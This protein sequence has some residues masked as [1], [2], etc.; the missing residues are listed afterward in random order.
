MKK[1]GY[2]LSIALLLCAAAALY[3]CIPARMLILKWF[4]LFTQ[5][6]T[7]SL[8][9]YIVSADAPFL[10]AV[11][12]NFFHAAFLF[13]YP[14]RVYMAGASCLGEW[15]AMAGAVL[16]TMAAWSFWYALG[17]LF[18]PKKVQKR[19][20]VGTGA[21]GSACA[22]VTLLFGNPLPLTALVTVLIKGSFAAGGFGVAAA[23]AVRALL[24]ARYCTLYTSYLP[25]SV[26]SGLMA[27][28]VALILLGAILAWRCRIKRVGN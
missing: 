11:F 8:Q 21:A 5:N 17:K 24:Y 1:R 12:L 16:G 19:K 28:G 3:F 14:P 2:I 7:Q 15:V 22:G 18:F 25:K 10:G 13:W 9:G 26:N 23:V 4:M 20:T 6:S 27:A